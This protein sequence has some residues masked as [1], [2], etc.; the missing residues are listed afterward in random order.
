MRS[1]NRKPRATSKSSES[2]GWVIP[3]AVAI[4]GLIGTVAVAL[5]N[6]PPV[7]SVPTPTASLS[8]AIPVSTAVPNPSH[9]SFCSLGNPTALNSVFGWQPGVSGSYNLSSNPCAL[10]IIAGPSKHQ[11]ASSNEAPLLTYPI[12]GDF[13]AKVRVVFSPTHDPELAGLGVRSAYDPYTWLRITRTFD[14]NAH[15]I[16]VLGDQKTNALRLKHDAYSSNTVYL[17]I[18]RKSSNFSFYYSSDNNNWIELQ[19]NFVFDMDNDT[20]IFLTAMSNV[21]T[22]AQFYDFVLIK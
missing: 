7:P 15:T 18:E 2:R 4:I 12:S 3:I 19:K 5:I 9:I 8:T 1:G 10:T 21:G 6:R 16:S 22:N 14:F 20:E 17:E 11:W 13:E